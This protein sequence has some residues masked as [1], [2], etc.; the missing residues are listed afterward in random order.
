[1]R[2]TCGPECHGS[3]V[4]PFPAE[5][6]FCSYRLFGVCLCH[7][8]AGEGHAWVELP[9]TLL[10]LIFQQGIKARQLYSSLKLVCHTWRSA[11]ITACTDL[12]V[13]IH[14]RQ[15][16]R[17][18]A[19]W[20]QA[21]ASA[22]LRSLD[23]H[24]FALPPQQKQSTAALIWSAMFAIPLTCLSLRNH[25]LPAESALPETLVHLTL[26]GIT[27]PQPNRAKPLQNAASMLTAL[28]SL[29]SL[30]IVNDESSQFPD[31][32]VLALSSLSH[33]TSLHLQAAL[34]H[35]NSPLH[36]LPSQLRTLNLSWN[37]DLQTIPQL[38]HLPH[39]Q[40]LNLNH[41]HPEPHLPLLD[42]AALTN[43]TLLS[44]NKLQSS[45]PIIIDEAAIFIPSQLQ[46]QQR[47]QQMQRYQELQKL[48]LQLQPQQQKQQQLRM[49]LLLQQQ[50]QHLQQ[51][52]QAQLQLQMQ[53]LQLQQRQLPNPSSSSSSN[54]T[55]R[56]RFQ[57]IAGD[58]CTAAWC[59]LHMTSLRSLSLRGY[60]LS[61][62]LLGN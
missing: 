16:A 17:A 19:S 22:N 24:L 5:T 58:D 36:A 18:L 4:S 32:C 45:S 44:V 8:Q 30:T 60:C 52:Q 2:C 23:V 48:Q 34:L 21:R 50:E 54:N 7:M 37:S 28:Q 49:S 26:R 55:R 39:L 20:L 53:E 38:H 31:A 12:N 46:L 40:A 14:H 51:Q 13:E 25:P 59:G 61:G 62:E 29:R 47:L 10:V 35:N 15:K 3:R 27:W 41:I 42:L 57:G 9:Q 1:M 33:L 56:S 6:L 11:A 43:L